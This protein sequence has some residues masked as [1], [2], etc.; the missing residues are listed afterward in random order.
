[1]SRIAL[2]CASVDSDKEQSR[3]RLIGG[4][5]LY[6]QILTLDHSQTSVQGEASYMCMFVQVCRQ[7]ETTALLK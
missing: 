2:F 4:K 3:I 6:F 7:F 1:M 5:N